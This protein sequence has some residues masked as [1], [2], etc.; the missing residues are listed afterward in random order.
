MADTP[1]K[2][3]GREVDQ[4]V[5]SFDAESASRADVTGLAARICGLGREGVERLARSILR[6]GP[7]RREKVAALLGCLEG[8][9]AAWALAELERVVASRRLS[10]ME[11]VWML[12]TLRRLE[13]AAAG[14]DEP[15]T[16]AWE[17]PADDLLADE[18]ELLLWRDELARLAPDE[19]EAVLAPLLHS[20]DPSM[21]PFLHMASTL[22]KPR[23]DAA[24]AGGLAHFATRDA[25]PLLRELLR[26]PDP[27]VRKGAREALVALERQGVATREVFVAAAEADEPISAAYVTSPDGQGQLAVLVARGNAP[28]RIRYAVVV[29]D[30]IDAGIARA[31]GETG[32]TWA[33]LAE[34]VAELAEDTDREF[35]S[36]A[37]EVAQALVAAGEVYA[38][39][40]GRELPADY[41][42]WRRCVGELRGRVEVP[43]VFGPSCSECGARMR[44]SDIE[45]G[46]V[47]AGDVAL[48]ARCAEGERECAVCGRALHPVFDEFFVRRGGTQGN[49]EFVCVRCARPRNRKRGR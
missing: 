24:I 17:E 28:G 41:L 33:D 20:G 10:P 43:V 34:R 44:G 19:Q 40:E 22:R 21:L 48:C 49:V 6:P 11:R 36:T 38:R 30:T 47:V 45:R 26:R 5:A 12:T 29:L 9:E 4:L 7:A 27:S 1:R 32:L 46:G 3:V 2:T 37:P 13:E 25:L 18:T 14:E 42:V 31:W 23:L 39:R 8:A 35:V 15:D 16:G